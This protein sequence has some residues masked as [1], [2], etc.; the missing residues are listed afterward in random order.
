[1]GAFT[2]G[3]RAGLDRA[4]QTYHENRWVWLRRMLGR[5]R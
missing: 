1:M 2:D 5:R 4:L 3:V